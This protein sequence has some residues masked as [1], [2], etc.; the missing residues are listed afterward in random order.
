MDADWPYLQD[1]NCLSVCTT[2]GAPPC[3]Q[4]CDIPRGQLYLIPKKSLTKLLGPAV[5]PAGLARGGG[6]T[7]TVI[8]LFLI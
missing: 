2:E 3:G 5:G 7:L 1:I 8:T 6:G 4:P